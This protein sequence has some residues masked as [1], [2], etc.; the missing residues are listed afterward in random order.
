[1]NMVEVDRSI[2]S[3]VHYVAKIVLR[4][5]VTFLSVAI[6][7]FMAVGW[8]TLQIQPRYEATVQLISGHGGL[9]KE[10]SNMRQPIEM[11]AALSAIAESAEVIRVAGIKAE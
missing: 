11:P 4:Y 6:V 5:K 7:F 8:L 9:Q 2:A 1:M 3:V 10:S